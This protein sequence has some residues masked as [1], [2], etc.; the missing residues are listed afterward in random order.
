[1][2]TIRRKG[3]EE[4][5]NQLP[6]LLAA[7]EK[8]R[9]T[10]ITRHGKAVAALVPVDAIDTGLRQQ[11]LLPLAGSGKGLWGDKSGETLRKLRDEWER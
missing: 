4:A 5:R 6:E 11:S 10:I 8:G 3:A 7:A 1:M 9:S 2:K